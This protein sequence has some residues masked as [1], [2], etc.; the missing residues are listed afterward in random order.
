MYSLFILIM[1]LIV[2]KKLKCNTIL[3]N[4]G[5][6]KGWEEIKYFDPYNLFG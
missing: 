4:R 6:L 3:I 5:A 1:I 2:D